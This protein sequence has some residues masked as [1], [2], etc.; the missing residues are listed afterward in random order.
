MISPH[1]RVKEKAQ[2]AGGVIPAQDLFCIAHI[3]PD[4]H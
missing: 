1:H 3:V 4:E 2:S